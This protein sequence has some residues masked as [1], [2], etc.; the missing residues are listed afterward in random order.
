M[1]RVVILLI[2]VTLVASMVSCAT[3]WYGLTIASTEGGSV[4]TPGEGAFDYE[5]GKLVDLIA[6]PDAG[7]RFVNWTGDVA[8][9][10][11]A[12][13]AETTITV[14]DN[15]EITA[16]FEKVYQLT[17][18]SS[19]GGS[20]T[21]PGEGAFLYAGGTMVSLVASPASG[22]RFVNWT[23]DVA[24]IAHVNAASTIIA[25]DG[26]YS[27]TA[28]FVAQCVLTIGS[29][30]GGEVTA[31]GKGTFTYDAGTVVNLVA[32]AEEGYRF[33]DWS[34]DVGTIAD[35]TAASTTIT[36][37][38]DFS[39]TANFMPA[40]LYF[41]QIGPG[42]WGVRV[43]GEGVWAT[44]TGEGLV[45][46]IAAD[47]VGPTHQQFGCFGYS[48]YTLAGD[49][50]IW[51]DYELTAW[52]EQSGIRVGL[53]VKVPD[54]AHKVNVERTGFGNP[55]RDFRY[56]PREVYLVNF[57]ETVYGI[58][59]TNDLSGTL[60]VCRVGTTVTGYYGISEGWKEI[61]RA[62]WSLGDVCLEVGVWSPGVGFFG[63]EAASVLMRTVK[64][65]ESLP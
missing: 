25:M 64:I 31:P 53:I 19:E 20:V 36:M 10:A 13:A 28:S 49:F 9:I 48:L 33:L 6:T 14:E 41:D 22:Y 37:T 30:E 58:V 52:P 42:L 44:V 7:Y 61:Y 57:D 34:G 16:N 40:H 62:E 45:V 60:R 54:T 5:A 26:D 38:E 35:P 47:A 4:H 59:S 21:A 1:K 2:A 29:T 27:I 17:V 50:D 32:E 24:T 65:V 39:I 63:G 11:D 56:Q 12:E 55:A 18:S 46:D 23:G 8:T 51:M 43:S 3:V 15:Y